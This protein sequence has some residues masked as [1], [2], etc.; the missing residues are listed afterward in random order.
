MGIKLLIAFFIFGVCACTL[1]IV[2]L[3]MPGTVLD[4]RWRAN[5]T[6]Q[7]GFREMGRPVSLLLMVAVGSACA[8]AAVGLA[9]QKAWG[10]WL[11]IAILVVNLGGDTLNALVRHDPRTLIGLPVAGVMI[12]YLWKSEREQLPETE[13]RGAGR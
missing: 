7:A 9:R 6:A 10:R 12:W 11:A 8:A 13:R 3:L 2:L 4:V 5:P 1:T